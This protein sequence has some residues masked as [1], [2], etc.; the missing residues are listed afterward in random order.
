MILTPV[1]EQHN[2]QFYNELADELPA[3]QADRVVLRQGLLE[4]LSYAMNRAH[5]GS[6]S[7]KGQTMRDQPYKQSC[8][9]VVRLHIRARGERRPGMRA[10]VS[11]EISRHLIHSLDGCVEIDDAAAYW[12]AT[13]YLPVAAAVPILVMDDNAG[14]VELFRRY[15]ADRNCQILTAQTAEEAL[16]Q[17]QEVNLRLI[18][19]DVMMPEQD[20]W[21]ILQR[22]RTVPVTAETPIIICSVLNEP[23]IAYTLG[24]SDYLPKPV[25]QDALLTK[26]EHWCRVRAASAVRPI[27]APASN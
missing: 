15:L 22:L 21:E 20:G 3:V 18:L 14:L 12:Q 25:T 8:S 17:A 6:I 11:L 7:I 23:E 24:A 2:I 16:A 4:L 5:A 26:V 9:A 27:E 13:V 10:G 19:L 1:A